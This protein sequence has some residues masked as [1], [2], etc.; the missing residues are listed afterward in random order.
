LDIAAW[1]RSLGLEQ[2]EDAFRK[3]AIDRPEVQ[4]PD[5]HDAIQQWFGRLSLYDEERVHTVVYV[6]SVPAMA[7]RRLRQTMRLS[8]RTCLRRLRSVAKRGSLNDRL[9]LLRSD[10]SGVM[11]RPNSDCHKCVQD[12]WVLPGALGGSTES[13]RRGSSGELRTRQQAEE[14]R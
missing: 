7:A 13:Q 14:R 12:G 4:A 6:Y 3:N 5:Y 2:Y 1:L 10:G 8:C 11:H 9:A